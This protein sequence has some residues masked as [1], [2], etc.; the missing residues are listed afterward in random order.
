MYGEVGIL[1]V[2]AGD[3]KLTFD[4]KNPSEVK[5]SAKI[6]KDMI[7]RGFVLLIEVG[8]DGEEPIYKRARDFD[9]NTCEYIIAGEISD[10][11]APSTYGANRDQEQASPTLR[12]GKATKRREKDRP[13][14][15]VPASRTRA[16]A[17]ARTAGG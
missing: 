15:R 1:N 4:P 12:A 2:G 11:A 14:E 13:A 7:R 16:V 3:T 9:E 5:R 10:E 17:V 6:V 8:R